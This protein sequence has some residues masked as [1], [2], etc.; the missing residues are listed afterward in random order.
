MAPVDVNESRDRGAFP[1]RFRVLG[2]EPHS[3]SLRCQ[4]PGTYELV[5]DNSYSWLTRKEVS[6]SVKLLPPPAITDT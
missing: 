3:G 4:E 6:Y 1:R 5:F 2:H